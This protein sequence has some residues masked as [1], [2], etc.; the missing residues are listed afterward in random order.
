MKELLKLQ[1]NQQYTLLTIVPSSFPICEKI[2]FLNVEI[3]EFENFKEAAYL[4][5]AKNDNRFCQILCP[6]I[7]YIIWENSIDINLEPLVSLFIFKKTQTNITE[8]YIK[9]ILQNVNCKPFIF[10][11]PLLNNK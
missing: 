8:I 2:T 1:K 9:Y 5:F 11:R 6:D 3:R 4:Y 10:Y 7:I